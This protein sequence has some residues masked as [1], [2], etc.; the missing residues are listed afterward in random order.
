MNHTQYYFNPNSGMRAFNNFSTASI[1]NHTVPPFT[2]QSSFGQ[3]WQP[4]SALVSRTVFLGAK[5]CW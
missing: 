4:N 5:L 2:M 3:L 1:T